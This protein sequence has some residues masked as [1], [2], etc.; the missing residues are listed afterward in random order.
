[1]ATSGAE[2][3]ISSG[4][5]AYVLGRYPTVSNTF[6]YREIARLTEAVDQVDVYALSRSD[7]PDHGV[8]DASVIRYTPSAHSALLVDSIPEAVGEAWISH[9]GRAKDLRRAGWLAR[10]WRRSGVS[11]VHAHFL[12]SA[13]AI[14]AAACAAAEIPLVVTVHARG[15][16]VPDSLAAFT[17]SQATSIVTI[18]KRTQGLVWER[19]G[20]ESTI[21]PV[22][23]APHLKTPPSSGELHV[24]TVARAVPKKGYPTMRAAVSRLQVPVKWTVVGASASE[25]GGPMEGLSA[26]GSTSFDVIEACYSAGV[27]VFAL[28]CEV[29]DDGD[30]DGIPVAILEA[31]ARGVPVVTTAVGGISELIT[32][33][34]T[35]LLVPPTD[36]DAMAAALA[37][38]AADP[39]LA[40]ALGEQGQTLVCTQRSPEQQTVEL[41]KCLTVALQKSVS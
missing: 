21:V 4:R 31:M 29:A 11:V 19:G 13:A 17:L 23:V 16:L 33:G 40:Q 41:M 22:P 35:G 34:Q 10:Q 20:R 36:P 15:I 32:D 30:E 28:A 8:L 27:D 12:G 5:V 26:L 2:A 14:A 25:I 37:R 3:G 38:L 7:G 6:V 18:S 1:V 39:V 24:L 9:G